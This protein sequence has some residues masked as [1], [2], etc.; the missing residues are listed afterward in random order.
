[1]H[2]EL[3]KQV[4]LEIVGD[5]V[6]MDK[7]VLEGLHDPLIHLIR[8]AIDHGIE[9]A[10]DRKAH[11]KP[12][13]GKIRIEVADEG[14]QI[15]ISIADDGDGIDAKKIAAVAES[16]G[17]ITKSELNNMN[18]DDILEL[19]FRPGFSTK[20]IITN[21]SGRG[22]GLDVVKANIADLKGQV[23]IKTKIGVGTTF[24]LRVPLTFMSERGLMV[25]TSG[26]TFVIPTNSVERVLTLPP[27]EIAEVESTQV[28][29]LD[30]RPIPLRTLADIIKLEKNE[31][32]MPTNFLLS[33]FERAGI[34]W[35]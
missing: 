21:V 23:S 12:D 28:I 27:E 10:T 17:I 6:K 31:V 4:D 26:Q 13:I 19:I 15:L 14:N 29:L 34:H 33:L 16:R 7:M 3:K 32:A 24:Y 8:N 22:V 18:N 5:E 1:M 11:G 35:H 2:K 25:S 9:N 30:G 20:E